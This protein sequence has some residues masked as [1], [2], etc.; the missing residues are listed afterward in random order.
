MATTTATQTRPRREREEELLVWPDLV[1]VEFICAVLFTF[2]FTIVSALVNA[3]L[4]N[5]ANVD[6]TPNPSKAPWYFLNLQEMLLHMNAALAG[7]VLPTVALI[8]LAAIPYLDRSREG[9]GTWFGTL[10]SV[11]ITVFSTIYTAFFGILLIVLDSGKH[12][13]VYEQITG[14]PWPTGKNRPSWLPDVGFI[15]AVWDLLTV[16][17]IRAIQ[18]EWTWSTDLGGLVPLLQSDGHDGRLDWPQDFTQIPLPFNGTSWPWHAGHHN[19]PEP[20][21]YQDL[22]DWLTGL[23][24]YDLNVNFPAFMVEILLPTLIMVGLS[25]LLVYILWRIRWVRTS[26]DVMIAVFT[27]FMV[28]FWLMTIVGSAFRGAGQELVWPWDVPRIDG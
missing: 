18:T 24:P 9:Q 13:Q 27:G 17:S 28:I 6:V 8:A 26:R 16:R 21:W 7:V 20:Q 14:D 15:N 10:N 1:F 2:S 23:L 3:P 25:V 12:A 22:P 19:T 4:I 11:R 5:R